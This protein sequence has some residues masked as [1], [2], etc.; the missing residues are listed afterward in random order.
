MVSINGEEINAKQINDD[1][2]DSISFISATSGVS[3]LNSSTAIPLEPLL[4]I[5]DN[6]LFDCKQYNISELDQD[7]CSIREV[8][9]D[10]LSSTK[11]SISSQDTRVMQ[12]DTAALHN[13]KSTSDSL[14][15]T[16]SLQ[17]N[18][19]FKTP[20]TLQRNK[21]TKTPT[22]V[23]TNNQLKYSNLKN[24]ILDSSVQK[25]LSENK[26]SSCHYSGH[27]K[28]V[29]SSRPV[30]IKRESKSTSFKKCVSTASQNN[31]HDKSKPSSS[32]SNLHSYICP[33]QSSNLP[34]DSQTMVDFEDALLL[35]EKELPGS[36]NRETKA[37]K[38]NISMKIN[39]ESHIES[40]S[41]HLDS[42]RFRTKVNSEKI[43]DKLVMLD[44][45]NSEGIKSALDSLPEK[46][47][48]Y[49]CKNVISVENSNSLS[50]LLISSNENSL[51]EQL[52]STKLSNKD[53]NI[54]CNIDNN[55]DKINHPK[56]PINE[57]I[58]ECSKSKENQIIIP[59]TMNLNLS[60]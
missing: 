39:N 57:T 40:V 36:I 4:T 9:S 8:N 34:E 2:N 17:R 42:S 3:C 12:A 56:L 27:R 16:S 28:F 52:T 44:K 55:S 47:S 10:T 43:V 35:L 7:N 13:F 14:K 26:I 45:V 5:N 38:G 49:S 60:G 25:S 21:H 18:K 41:N 33:V 29:T 46:V 24:S 51:N 48:E 59:E 32:T 1:D 37:E 22:T 31:S 20:N 53:G 19:Q 50:K 54:S 11:K 23:K 15:S 30:K 58:Y 6:K